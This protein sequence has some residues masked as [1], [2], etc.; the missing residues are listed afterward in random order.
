MEILYALYAFG[1]K[2]EMT[3]KMFL[4]KRFSC[5]PYSFKGSNGI[6]IWNWNIRPKYTDSFLVKRR[7][8]HRSQIS[9]AFEGKL[10]ERNVYIIL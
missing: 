2:I 3:R 8:N 7:R 4:L 9:F 1:D 5:E 10:G 6:W